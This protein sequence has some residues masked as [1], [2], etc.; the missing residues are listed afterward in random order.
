MSEPYSD[1]LRIRA[2][3]RATALNS[4]LILVVAVLGCYAGGLL[5]HWLVI[6]P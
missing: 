6:A 5:W 4:L 3:K 2:I 1:D